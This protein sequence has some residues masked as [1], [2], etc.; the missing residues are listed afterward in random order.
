MQPPRWARR[1]T[2]IGLSLFFGALFT[3]I[4]IGLLSLAQRLV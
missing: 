4:G 2:I 1:I 3:C